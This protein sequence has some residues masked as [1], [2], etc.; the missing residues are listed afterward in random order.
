MPSKKDALLVALRKGQ[1]DRVAHM[2][3]QAA[4]SSGGASGGGGGGE[5]CPDMEADSARNGI[6]HRAARYGHLEIVKVNVR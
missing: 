1:A 4:A 2:L 6:L 3:D 5:L